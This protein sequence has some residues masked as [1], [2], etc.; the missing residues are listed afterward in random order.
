MLRLYAT[1]IIQYG[2]LGVDIC[3]RRKSRDRITTINHPEPNPVLDGY[4]V[5]ITGKIAFCI[6][7]SHYNTTQ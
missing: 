3:N 4:T 1:I 7:R 2:Y 5:E 6:M